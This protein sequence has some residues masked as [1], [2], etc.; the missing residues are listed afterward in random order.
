[1]WYD[2][3]Y[4][5]VHRAAAVGRGGVLLADAP[6]GDHVLPDARRAHA[7]LQADT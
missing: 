4:E 6:R 2:I 1:M 3:I 5:R 7:P